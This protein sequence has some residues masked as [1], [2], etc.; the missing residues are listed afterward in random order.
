MKI[1]KRLFTQ[2]RENLPD[3]YFHVNMVAKILS[4]STEM[5]HT[6]VLGA[7]KH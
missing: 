6:G 3:R 1:R 4:I 5:P 2:I 7:T